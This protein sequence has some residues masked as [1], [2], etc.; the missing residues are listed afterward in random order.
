MILIINGDSPVP[1]P[2][3]IG[4][5]VPPKTEAQKLARKNKLNAKST[6]L[7]AI[8]DEHLLKF[9][10][11]KDAESLWE[12]INIR[13]G[14]NKV[15]KK[16]HKTILK[17]QYE[18]F[19]ASRSEGL[20]KT[21]DR[22]LPPAWNNIVLIMR[23][24]PDIETLSMDD[25]YNNLKVYEA[26][27]KGQSSSTSNSHNVAFVSSENTSS[28]N[29][30]VNATL[31]IP[32]AGSK[33]QP[34]TSSYNDDVAMITIKVKKFMK[35][36]GRNLNFNG[37][38]PVGFDKT[39]VESYNCHRRGHFA[40]ECRALRNQGN[41]S[42]DN[43]KKS[44]SS[45]DSYKCLGVRRSYK[46]KHDLKEKL[47]KFEESSKNSTKLIN[48]QMS[49]NEKT[50]LGYDNQ[51]SENEMPKCE[52]FEVTS[53]SSVN[54]I[55]EDN[56]QAKDR[57]KVGI[58]YHAVPLPC[59]ENYMPPRAD[60]SFAGLDD[61]VFKFK[62]SE[63][64]TSV[65]ENESIA[66]KSSEEIRE[67][68]KTVRVNWN[69]MKTQ[70]QGIGFEFNKRACFVCGSVNHLIKDCIFYENKMVEKS[71]VNNKGKGTGQ[72]EVRPVSNNARKVNH[73]NFSKMTHP[74]PKRNFVPIA[75][76]T[77]SGQV[78][79]NA[80]KQSSAASTGNARPKVNTPAIRPNV[81]AK[82]FYFKPYFPKRRNF[83]QR[84]AAKT[85]TFSRKINIAKGKNVTTDGPKAVVNVVDG[86]KKNVVKS[87]TYWIWRPKGKLINHTSK[88][89]GSY[90]L[91]RFNYPNGRLKSDQRIFDN[92]CSRHITG[93]GKTRT[94]K[95][96][97]EDVYFV[98]ELK[99]NLFY[100]LQMC[101][102]KNN[103][104]FIE[105]ECLVL[106]PDF[107]LLD[108]SQ[109]LL[110]VHRQNNMCSFDLKN[111]V[112]TRDLTCLFAK[113]IIDESNLWYR[114]L[115]HINF[116]TSN[117]LVR[118]NLVR[119]LPSMNSKND[120]SY[121]AC[122]KGKQHKA[123]CKTKL[124][125][126]ISQPLQML[127][128]DLFGPTFVKSL[129]KKMYCLV[130]TD[131]FSR[132][133]WVFF[134][135]SKD[136]TSGILKTFVTGIENQLN[137]RVKIIRC[138]NETEFK[139]SEMYQFCQMK[140]IKRE[141]SV[142][143]TP[144]QNEVVE[145][146]NRTLIENRV[147][148]TKPHNKT[149][150]ELLIGRSPNLEFMIP[151]GCP[152][153]ILNT[154]DHLEKFDEKV[155]EGFLVG[156]SVNSKAF[157]FL[158][159][160]NLMVIQSSNVNVGDKPGDIDAGD[161]PRDVNAG[162]IQGDIDEIL[163]NDDVCQGNVIRINSSTHAVNATSPSINIASNI[164]DTGSLN[165]N[166][167]DY[168]HTNMTTLE[169]TDIF[170]GAFSDRD[171]G[172]EAD[173][174]NLVSSTVEE[175]IDYGEVFAPVARIEAIRLFL[176][177]ASFK[178]FIVYQMDVKSAFLYGKIEEEV[179]VYQPPG[180]EDPDFPDKVYKV[181]K[182]LYGDILLVQVYV[183]D[184]I[185]GSTKKEMCDAFAIL[186][187]EKF[188]ISSMGELTFF[189]GLQVK[190]KQDII[191]ISQDK[192]VAEILK[193]FGFSE[194]KTASTP[195][196]TSN[197]LLKDE[198]GQEVDERM[199]RSMIGSLM[200]LTSL[201]PDIMF[202]VCACV[203]HQV[204]PK[205][206]HLHAVKRI[207]R[208]LKGQPKLGLW[209]PKDSPFKLEAY[210][211]SD[212]AGS[213]L[214]KKSTTGGCQFLGCRLISLQCKKQTV[215]ANSTTKAEYVAA[216]SCC[217]QILWIQNQLLDY[218]TMASAIICLA[219]NQKFNFSKYI[220]D[221]MVKSLEG[222]VKFYLFLRFLQVFLDKQVKRMAR[223]KEMY[224]ISSHTKKIFANMRR[225]GAGFSGV[226]TSLFDTMMVQ[227]P[228]DMGD[229]PVDTHQTPIVDQPS[230][231]K[232][233]K[234]QKP[235][236]KQ[237]KDAEVFNDELE[238]D[239]HV[240]TPSNDPLPSGRRVKPPMEKD[241]LGTQEDAFKQ[242]RMIEEIDQNAEIALD[243]ETQGST[244]D[245][246]M[247]GVDDLA[248][249]EVVMDTTTGKHEE[250]IIEDVSTAK[251]VT[252]AG[253][254]V[255]T[256][257][258]KDSAAS[259]TDVTK[260]EITMAQAM[261]ALKSIKPKVVVQEQE[262][263]TII[264][265]VATT[266][267]TA[268]LTPRAKG[269]VF[270]EQ[271]QTQIPTVSSSKDKG[272]AKMIEHKVPIKKKDQTRIDE[273]YARKLEAEEQETARLSRAQ[274]DEEANNSW[275]NI[276]AMMDADRLLAERIQS[277]EMEEFSKVQ[278]ARLEMR[279][280]NDFIAMDL[281]AQESSTKRTAEHLESDISKK[282]KVDENVEPVIDD[283]KELKNCIEIVPDDEDEVLIEATSL[284][285]RSPTIIDYKIH[286]EGKKT[287]FKI[288]I[289]DG[290]SQVY[291]TFEKMFKNFNREDL[292][293]LWAIVKDRFKKEKPMD[294]KDNLLFRTLK[295]MF[296]HHV[297]DN[298]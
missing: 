39:R 57:Y 231:S 172:A 32:A 205:A 265:A 72:R 21:Y 127:H 90:T 12:A 186:M 123:S 120:H 220:F 30:T 117:K 249:E 13:F 196:E 22:S 62:I 56:N 245:D 60:L 165:I 235:R 94:G 255:T 290:N 66:S 26:E 288:I 28:I 10:S 232:P 237:K 53:D 258:V 291:Q 217:R 4:T 279:T 190:Q 275:D 271:K 243:D 200:Y 31:D 263:S 227:A 77:K 58:G 95:L 256:T 35:K 134:L 143:R 270:H 82:S 142:V 38:D 104:L 176:P 241:S 157:R 64:R 216:S 103:V 98:K 244:N 248:G 155:D 45:R 289:V 70:K 230:T 222:G 298:I 23:N 75:V 189:L 280:V 92:G 107:K 20:D 156:Y 215:V 226:I 240:P 74:H 151:F 69:G 214:D 246:E 34:F 115:G 144:Q 112:P 113:A 171:L 18:N 225:I 81:N 118:G 233:Q 15:S 207:F 9:H 110:K 119:G 19:I 61:S 122:K 274:Q 218:S 153:T 252:T 251:P 192:Y 25:L 68:P 100:V 198:D 97:F 282:Q 261:A 44:C 8:L 273:E 50:G 14:G 178:D 229:T 27:I 150:Y 114:R 247:F 88:D 160:I 83:N 146:K 67:E 208:Y 16:M 85:N 86:N 236:R 158:H 136:E 1:E 108:E 131:D 99:F 223:H 132:F 184:I 79:V 29:E 188:Q 43:I 284:S 224:I 71:V 93:K 194:V 2:P 183:D 5:V 191:F 116:K 168:N 63:T 148:V 209:Y 294:D 281:E 51:L 181:K 152:I 238:D 11:I 197:P 163:R 42:G 7:L 125:S 48:S 65:N 234:K 250:Q 24:K 285:S 254:V 173:T 221:N 185:F 199:Y 286:K 174:N 296:K 137:H 73:Q 76:A 201:R 292:E 84:S 277:R 204:S 239:D 269:I 276:Q 278:K 89:S 297:E 206:S 161:K 141:F 202:V 105:T 78:L 169:A 145:K 260:D 295:T 257:I 175:G 187:H 47:T 49:A 80:G 287:Y 96:D 262:M 180:F 182:A 55:D 159:G 106:S 46:R 154:I 179:Y 164:I 54:E 41:K 17:Q 166:T 162:D 111:V 109:V 268:V 140:G 87:S 228:A 193:K 267:T 3:A 37:K 210:T 149:P 102:K 203:R 147:L 266:V 6:L 121:V 272:K 129:Y 167:A 170:D 253:E 138:D 36:T 59:T 126:Y 52:I 211:D 195:M 139:N 212:Y 33:E 133:S 264:P 293:V 124:V 128:M 259:T 130:I 40:R 177:Y 135:A 91:K 283:S 242:G 213:S 101:D 219:D